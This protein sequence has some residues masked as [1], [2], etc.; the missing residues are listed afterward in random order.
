MARFSAIGN[1]K[2]QLLDPY[3]NLGRRSSTS[4]QMSDTRRIH[5]FYASQKTHLKN[6]SWRARSFVPV[7][8]LV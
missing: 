7:D 5:F 3:R 6:L 2:E 1:T 4:A 8:E